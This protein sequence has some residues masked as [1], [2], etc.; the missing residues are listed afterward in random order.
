MP[1]TA[2]L[3]THRTLPGQRAAVRAV[4]ER[5]MRPAVQANA[6]HLAYHYCFDPADPDVIHAFQQYRSEQ[7]AAAFLGTDAYRTYER[8][9][10]PLLAGPPVV[11]RLTP[12][13]TKTGS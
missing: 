4:W 12:Q 11:T 7:D 10:A 5:L 9:V 2:L 1:S 8:D 13:W 6:G 3:I